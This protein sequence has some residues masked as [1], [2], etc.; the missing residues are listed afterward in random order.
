MLVGHEPASWNGGGWNR[1]PECS[2]WVW[3]LSHRKPLKADPLGLRF[4]PTGGSRYCFFV[5][6]FDMLNFANPSPWQNLMKIR[7]TSVI[8][9]TQWYHTKKGNS[10]K[11]G[12]RTLG[13]EMYIWNE[14]ESP[15]PQKNLDFEDMPTCPPT[16]SKDVKFR[17]AGLFLCGFLMFSNFRPKRRRD[18]RY[19]WLKAPRFG[20]DGIG[21]NDV[22]A[23]IAQDHRVIPKFE[24][25]KRA[26]VPTTGG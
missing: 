5:L 18:P 12:L 25:W 8:R 22:S 13:T 16:P 6:G 10:K 19:L 4:D 21:S 26:V 1:L 24:R 3:N 20:F 15:A 23:F 2:V 14:L 7:A 11:D 17:T 9:C